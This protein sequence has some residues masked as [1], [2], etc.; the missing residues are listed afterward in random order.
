MRARL[1]LHADARAALEF[2]RRKGVADNRLVLYGE[3]L[4]S[5]VAVE[6][7]AT[8]PVAALVLESPF[9]SI[10]AL[11]QHHYPYVPA[12]LL[13]RDRFDALSRIGR[14]TAP[15]LML[16]GDRDRVVPAR[17]GEALFAAAPE[18]KER[19]RA[20]GAGHEELGPAGALDAV[21][22][23]LERRVR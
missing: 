23:V 15:I 17:F 21:V 7:A 11:A 4:G 14:V 8:T 16:Q 13:V 10:A 18:P 3:S 5:A 12:M 6:V 9:T 22:A 2:L 20:P 19:W 1:A